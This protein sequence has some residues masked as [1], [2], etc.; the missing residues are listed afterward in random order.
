MVDPV[1]YYEEAGRLVFKAR[2]GR[3]TQDELARRVALTRTSITNIEKGRQRVMLHTLAQIAE[4]LGT[5]VSK[6]LPDRKEEA[7]KKLSHALKDHPKA[8]RDWVK[9]AV[10][11]VKKGNT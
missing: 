11:T 4:A 9:E 3:L 5:T 1:E 6:L 8:A 2:R 7:G 10:Q